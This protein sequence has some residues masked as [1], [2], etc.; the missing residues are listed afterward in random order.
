MTKAEIRKAYKAKRNEISESSI[1]EMSLAIANQALDLPIWEAKTFHLFMSIEQQKEVQTEYL[2]HVLYG[3]DKTVVV[4]K[5]D[6]ETKLMKSVLLTENT[7]LKPNQMHIP[8]PEDGIEINHESID[9]VFVPLLAYDKKG[10]R[11]GYG[12]GFYDRFLSLCRPDVIKVGLSFFE[13]EEEFDFA[14]EFDIQMDFCVTPTQLYSFPP[15]A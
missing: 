15:E 7:R 10:F 4:P 9:I 3:K 2:L 13:A 14:E 12:Q 5:S 8:E 6:F 1:A 11:V